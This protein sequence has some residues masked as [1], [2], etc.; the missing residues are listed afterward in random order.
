MLLQASCDACRFDP[1]AAAHGPQHHLESGLRRVRSRSSPRRWYKRRSRT[2][3]THSS[4]SGPLVTDS[5]TPP[6]APEEVAAPSRLAMRFNQPGW[7]PSSSGAHP[8]LMSDPSRA[9]I[10]LHRTPGS[11]RLPLCSSGSPRS[12][13]ALQQPDG[14]AALRMPLMDVDVVELVVAGPRRPP[15]GTIAPCRPWGRKMLFYS[16][17]IECGRIGR[18]RPY[19]ALSGPGRPC[20]TLPRRGLYMTPAVS[21]ESIGSVSCPRHPPCTLHAPQAG[22]VHRLDHMTDE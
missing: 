12:H 3:A 15:A 4:P 22:V 21:G 1:N 20:L 10:P 6:Q 2:H 16:V 14:E 18:G 11:V 8:M 5:C 9:F 7:V 19:G 17:W 13:R